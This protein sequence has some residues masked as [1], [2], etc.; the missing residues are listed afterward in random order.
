MV[1]TIELDIWGSYDEMKQW[2]FG[3][4]LGRNQMN[5]E[6]VCIQLS[7][8]FKCLLKIVSAFVLFIVF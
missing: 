1:S 3:V 6:T 7:I 2:M 5:V 4:S 8:Y